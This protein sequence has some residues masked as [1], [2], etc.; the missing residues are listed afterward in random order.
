MT[1]WLADC[2]DILPVQEHSSHCLRVRQVFQ[3]H[4]SSVNTIHSRWLPLS[5]LP[6][7]GTTVTPT[8]RAGSS[9]NLRPVRTTFLHITLKPLPTN[10]LHYPLLRI[11][12][13]SLV[14]PTFEDSITTSWSWEDSV[15]PLRSPPSSA[16]A[17]VGGSDLLLRIVIILSLR[18]DTSTS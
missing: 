14:R 9:S 17:L 12:Y 13:P 8:D 18:V 5:T 4:L 16:K 7:T 1:G 2:T 6:L 10:P 15:F 11:A 3:I